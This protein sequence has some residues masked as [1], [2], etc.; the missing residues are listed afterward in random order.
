MLRALLLIV[1][2]LACKPLVFF[3]IRTPAD[4]SRKRARRHFPVPQ[5]EQELRTRADYFFLSKF[6]VIHKRR[7][8]N[9]SQPFVYA[10]RVA[11]YPIFRLEPDFAL[12]R[13]PLSDFLLHFL[14]DFRVLLFRKA[15]VC[16]L[17]AEGSL[18]SF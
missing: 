10:D 5:R 13:F 14:Y 6:Q 16:A 7:G 15:F 12:E 8:V 2:K 18:R 9:F 17:R 3:R 4:G 11:S 1:Y